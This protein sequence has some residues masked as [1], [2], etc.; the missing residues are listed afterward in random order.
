M[1]INTAF[2]PRGFLWKVASDSAQ[3]SQL[4][5]E[6]NTAH[7]LSRSHLSIT[8]LIAEKRIN[9]SPYSPLFILTVEWRWIYIPLSDPDHTIPHKPPSKHPSYLFFTNKY[10]INSTRFL[11]L[12]GL[13]LYGANSITHR[14]TLTPPYFRQ[15]THPIHTHRSWNSPITNLHR[16]CSIYFKSKP[17]PLAFGSVW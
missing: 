17:V 10:V 16:F 4:M 14:V 2:L 15:I 8:I 1:N 11:T 13:Y 5:G 9:D 6:K 7:N 3:I 12:D